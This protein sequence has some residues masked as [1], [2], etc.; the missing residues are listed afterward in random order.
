MALGYKFNMVPTFD[1]QSDPR[2]L[3]MS[4][5]AAVISGGGDETTLAKSLVMAVK[6]PTQQ[7][8]SSLKANFIHSGDQLKANLLV[9]F[10]GFQPTGHNYRPIQL[11]AT[12]QRTPEPILQ[13]IYPNQG[14]NSKYPR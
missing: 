2:Q 1:G 11:Q 6:G 9:D 14:T 8:Y 5:E 4:F 3:L 13:K 12:T 10:Q 7:W